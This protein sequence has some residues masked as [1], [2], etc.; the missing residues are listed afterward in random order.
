MP[1]RSSS[2]E[3][4]SDEYRSDFLM[5]MALEPIPLKVVSRV[6]CLPPSAADFVEF[7]HGPFNG[8]GHHS[9]RRSLTD[10]RHHRTIRPRRPFG[11]Y[12]P[13]KDIPVTSR[14]PAESR[15]ILAVTPNPL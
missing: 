6:G 7:S 14:R 10:V 13:L 9:S 3:A 8:L 2:Q 5:A 12:A 15:V 1:P 4:Q 11:A